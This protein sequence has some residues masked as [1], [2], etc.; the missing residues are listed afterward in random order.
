MSNANHKS[1]FDTYPRKTRKEK[2]LIGG[3]EDEEE[4]VEDLVEEPKTT[5]VGHWS[6]NLTLTIVQDSGK[7]DVEAMNPTMK[8]HYLIV[9]GP[10]EGSLVYYLL[11][12]RTISGYFEKT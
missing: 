3:D 6:R 12:S 9:P 4:Q 1:S 10:S 7:V 5:I 8:P 2:K 11:S